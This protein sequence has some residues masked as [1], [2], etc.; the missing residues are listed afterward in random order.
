M[1]RDYKFV[2]TVT[3]IINGQRYE[4]DRY[5]KGTKIKWQ[6]IKYK[7]YEKDDPTRYKPHQFKLMPDY[8]AQLLWELLTFDQRA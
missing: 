5:V 1:S 3:T 7:T 8:A 4:A 6:K 2:D